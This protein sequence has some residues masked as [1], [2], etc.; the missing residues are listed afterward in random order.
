M[1]FHIFGSHTM[2]S[3]RGSPSFELA[4]NAL[5]QAPFIWDVLFAALLPGRHPHRRPLRTNSGY[6]SI[7][8]CQPKA[9]TLENCSTDGMPQPQARL[10]HMETAAEIGCPSLKPGWGI[11]KL[12]R[13]WYAP[14]LSS[15]GLL[16]TARKWFNPALN[17]AG[18]LENCS[19]NTMP[20][21]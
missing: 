10:G 15:V 12:Q 13:K 11:G 14:A 3:E 17:K 5:F 1:G 2:L 21:P 7:V 8:T 9:R 6:V 18:A 19:K 20:Q 16:K 4:F